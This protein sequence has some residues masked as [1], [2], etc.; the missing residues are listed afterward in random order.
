MAELTPEIVGDVIK[1][2]RAAADEI[3]AALSRAL[4]GE[5]IGITIGEGATYVGS[6]PA[7][8]DGPGLV[9]LLKFGD[10]GAVA[11]LPESSG[12]LPDW[13]ADPDST[14]RSKLS[15]L[16]QELSLLLVPESLSADEFHAFRVEKLS[17]ALALAELAADAALLP[18]SL[19]CDEK[20]GQ[21]SL[22]WPVAK[23][24]ELL[25]TPSEADSSQPVADQLG[26]P[27]IDGQSQSHDAAAVSKL[28][29]HTRS[30]FK[31]RVPVSVNL[32][33]QKQ[34]VQ[35]IL[36]LVP[37][38]IIKFDKSCDELS[39][40]MVGDQPIAAGEVVKVGDKFGLRIRDMFQPQE[41]LVAIKATMAN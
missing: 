5:F 25:P 38:S 1:T 9:V 16:A 2:C 27:A 39:D 41:Q 12:L 21:L 19:K 31:V 15:T 26:T 18:M 35:D 4:D 32:A 33:S 13:F 36:E 20:Q 6:P 23:P 10:A 24:G 29:H 28:P 14:G 37:G 11:L 34:S 3:G 22:I 7:G 40:L 8:C 17:D 30:L